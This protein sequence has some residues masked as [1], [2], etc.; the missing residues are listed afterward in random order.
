[1][2]VRMKS[3]NHPFL[4]LALL[5]C[6][7]FLYTPKTM[8]GPLEN[9]VLHHCLDIVCHPLK[10]AAQLGYMM[11][12]PHGY[13]H[14]CYTPLAVYIADTPEAAM[15]ACVAGLTS[16][17]TMAS[18]KQFGD[19]FRHEPRTGST[20]L[21]QIQE[22]I[23]VVDPWD[24]RA[25]HKEALHRFRLSATHLPVWRDWVLSDPTHFL[26]PE[27]LHHWHKF[28][29]D[30]D[31]Q[32]C[33]NLLGDAE[34]NFRF[35][36]LQPR[37]GFRHFGE[38]IAGLKQSTGR[39]HRDIQR[40]IIS[41]ITGIAPRPFLIALRALMDFRYLA[42]SKTL[43]D[44]TLTKISAALAEFHEHKHAILDAR[45]RLGGKNKPINN[46]EIPKLEMMHSVTSST[47][48]IGPLIQWS[49]DATEHCNITEIKVPARASNNKNHDTQICRHLDRSEKCRLFDLATTIR[50]SR[51]VVPDLTLANERNDNLSDDEEDDAV[52][53][54]ADPR[55]ILSA[56][57]TAQLSS[58][59]KTPDYFKDAHV[60]LHSPQ[61]N[62]IR[63]LRTFSTTSTAFHLNQRANTT[64]CSVDAAAIAFELVDLRPALVDYVQHVNSNLHHT[65]SIGGRRSAPATGRQLPFKDIEI[66]HQVKIQLKAVHDETTVMPPYTLHAS[67]P[68]KEWPLGRYDPALLINDPSVRWPGYGIA[69]LFFNSIDI[70]PKTNLSCSRSFSGR[71]AHAISPL[72]ECWL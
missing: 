43:D 24:I 47:R 51:V 49:A 50:Q 16:H 22:L 55:F 66:W 21:A 72:L 15:L 33:I 10:I 45:V 69:G 37:T 1:M 44:T 12:D 56:V 34:I 48:L 23:G 6:P 26:P 31:V 67:P 54:R 14:T 62:I 41:V 53:P 8:R 38:G 9:R 39:E 60:S 3:S 64:K 29:Y 68:S 40:Y 59:R 71:S 52:D 58:S 7:K 13:N 19:S 20:T 61:A 65:H 5:P 70:S 35:H 63:P 11:S 57:P 2:D 4:L 42:Q 46:F 18:Y 36:L 25:Y 32:W 28:F 17:M 27:V 30:H